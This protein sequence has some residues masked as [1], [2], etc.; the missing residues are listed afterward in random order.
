MLRTILLLIFTLIIVPMLAFQFDDPLNP[1]QSSILL[2][3]IKIYL[4]MAILTFGISTLT[5]NYSQVDKLWSVIPIIYAGI[6][7]WFSDFEPRV[8]LMFALVTVWALRLS[9][10]FMR[11]GG[12]SWKFWTGEEDYRW[13]VLRAKPEF[14][15]PI[16]WILFNL[17]FISLYQMGLI[18]LFTL[19][20]LKSMGGAPLNFWDL[21]ISA[22]FLGFVAMETI[23][24]QQQ[25]KYQNEKH[26]R[27]NSKEDLVEKYGKGF[28]HTGLWKWFRHPNY[29]A[30]QAIWIVFYL[31]TIVATGHWINWAIV[32]CLLLLVL[33][34]GSSD[35]S[36][37]IS[38]SKYPDYVNYQ[39]KTGRFFPKI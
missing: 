28:T 13:E 29:A 37:E 8:L 19:P 31:F 25:W 30:E 24:D 4:F 27:I 12:Y 3:L 15:K 14:S 32:G 36:E 20:I 34:K 17:F 1:D 10:N 35:F 38:Q 9:Y 18:L 26:R 39:K 11:R 21:I 33:F 5:K 7:C 6:V 23:A 2:L 16:S 22:L